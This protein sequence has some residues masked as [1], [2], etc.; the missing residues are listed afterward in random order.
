MKNYLLTSLIIIITFTSSF[1]AD[2]NLKSKVPVDKNVKTG[3]FPNGMKYYIKSNAKPEKNAHFR[4]V[5]NAGAINE[6][7]DQN[8]LAHFTEHMCF[9]GTKNFPKNEL[10]DFLQKTGIQFGADVNAATGLERTM[11]ELP[12]SIENPE[13]IDNALLVLEDW[14]H[15]VT[16]DGDQI[17]GERGVI[18]SEWRQRNNYQFRLGEKRADQVYYG[19]KYAQRNLIGDTNLLWNFKYDVIRRFYKDWYRPDLQAIIAVGDFDVNEMYNKIEKRF[20][21]IPKR[22]NPRKWEAFSMPDHN[23]TL[24]S[25]DTDKEVPVDIALMFFKIPE[26]DV[27]TYQG[28]RERIKRNLHDIMFNQRIQEI[29]NQP[30][31]P[32]IQAGGGESDFYGD[33]RSYTLYAVNQGGTG[34]NAASAMLDEAFRVKQHGFT[35]SEFDRA[36]ET[37]MSS[38]TNTLKQ[39]N[40]MPHS[41]F[42]D[43][44]T[45]NFLVGEPM[46]GI[47]ADLEISENMLSQITL[48]EIN[49]L[50]EIYLT[51]E[52][53]VLTLGMPEMAELKVP[54]EEEF[55]SLY[56]SKFNQKYDAYEDESSDQPLFAK[57]LTPGKITDET[58]NKSLDLYELK[59]SNG[60]KVILKK[61]NYTENQILLSAVSTGGT[62]LISDNDYYTGAQA[63][64]IISNCGVAEFSQT[65]LIKKLTGKQLSLAPY[66]N[67]LNEGMRG[68][69]SE[70]DLETFMQV[71]HL[72]FTNPRKDND[73]FTSLMQ[74]YSAY[75]ANASQS[76][77]NAFSDTIQVTMASYH[78]REQPLTIETLKKLDLDAAYNIFTQRFGDASDFTFIF[79]GSFDLEQMKD[80]S[81]K[82]I[83]SL[84]S[85]NSK[86]T[87]KD[88]GIEK[89]EKAL[90]K[91]IKAGEED[92]AHVRLMIP[93]EFKWG[94][95]ER[96]RMQSMIDYFD[97]KFTEQIREE[98][99]GV[100]SPGIWAAMEKYPEAEYTI[101]I[102]FV[103]DPKRV[104][105]MIAAVKKLIKEVK[106]EKDDVTAMKVQKAQRTQRDRNMKENGYWLSTL[107]SYINNG[108]EIN[109]ILDW[110]KQI[111]SLNADD[112]LK[113]AQKYLNDDKMIKI[114][115]EPVTM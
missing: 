8:G 92:K 55:I 14:A 91:V 51:K 43:E 84:P 86:E 13:M 107:S 36:K 101:N 98:L 97:I 20:A 112:I 56:H 45:N 44:Y 82:Y 60:A 27:T 21:S 111:D 46:P 28:Y 11:Y 19:S 38:L 93:G 68:Q 80:L 30:N 15:N 48:S 89:P 33:K 24:A 74:K 72:Y 16:F 78:Y 1:A 103:T 108:E 61:T 25:I 12:I 58:Y 29:T 47:D 49:K 22:D 32:F 17:D 67:E 35:A 64:E 73:A 100:Y 77:E 76:P 10:I 95:N 26:Y 109:T 40:T 88:V 87:W 50:S 59:L 18:V 79:V 54:K 90:S 31:P 99:G 83:G 37:F 66:I 115:L 105:E 75:L 23:M 39:K 7:D 6:D 110:D 34:L 70:T 96:H 114:I 62:S 41:S 3:T 57:E 53:T 69:T 52:N 42:V 102:D 2:Y 94:Q 5:V 4:L 65:D 85:K 113:A 106:T 104:D 81:V 71:M 63:A 9:N